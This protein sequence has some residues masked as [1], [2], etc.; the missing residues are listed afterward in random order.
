VA[1]APL[2][3]HISART[4]SEEIIDELISQA[5]LSIVGSF[6]DKVKN[7]EKWRIHRNISDELL[8]HAMCQHLYW[9]GVQKGTEFIPQE[10]KSE[11]KKKI[12]F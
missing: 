11:F 9:R 6:R 2:T 5:K 10:V 12:E 3:N 4:F 7:F 1:L 8:I